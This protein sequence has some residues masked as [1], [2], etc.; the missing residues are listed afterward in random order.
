VTFYSLI[1]YVRLFLRCLFLR[2]LAQILLRW[3]IG[4]RLVMVM[5]NIP[6]ARAFVKLWIAGY[7]FL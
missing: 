3:Q 4:L 5:V 7:P 6:I 1:L 2:R